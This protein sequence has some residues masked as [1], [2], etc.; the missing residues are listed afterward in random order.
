IIPWYRASVAQDRMSR[1][2]A[3]SAAAGTVDQIPEVADPAPIVGTN[4]N[5]ASESPADVT[6]AEFMRSLLRD[7]LFPAMRVDPV[8]LRAFLR[9][10]NL[11][12]PPDSLMTNM[13]VI[14]RVMVV[15]QDRENRAP[16]PSLGPDRDGLIAEAAL[17]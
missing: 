14:G 15:Y 2:A 13:D 11:L 12:E 1:Q 4:G 9:M 8:V 5:E 7:G 17:A 16:E 3:A 6:S 10:F